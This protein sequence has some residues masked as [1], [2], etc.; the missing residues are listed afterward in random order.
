[1]NCPVCRKALSVFK[2]THCQDVRCSS[3]QCTGT[4]GAVKAAGS[5]NRTCPVC[6]SG[7]L[8]KI[9]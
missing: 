3:S 6:K 2:C 7:K 9:G 1:M 4:T 8:E 5:N